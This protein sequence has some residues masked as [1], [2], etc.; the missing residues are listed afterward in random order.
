MCGDNLKAAVVAAMHSLW[1]SWLAWKD[2]EEATIAGIKVLCCATDVAL[3]G[4]AKLAN[5]LANL[6]F[7]HKSLDAAVSDELQRQPEEYVW[8]W[9]STC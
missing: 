2:A 1:E 3:K 5:Y 9:P 7:R 6:L 8:P 4:V